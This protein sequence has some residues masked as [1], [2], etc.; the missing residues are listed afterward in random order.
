[1]NGLKSPKSASSEYCAPA[2]AKGVGEIKS[3]KSIISSYS[4]PKSTEIGFCTCISGEYCDETT[5][6]YVN[7][8]LAQVKTYGTSKY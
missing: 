2:S 3:G 5:V 1:M 6:E 4:S 8:D 7:L